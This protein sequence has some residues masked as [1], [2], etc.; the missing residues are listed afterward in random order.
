[1]KKHL[2]SLTVFIASLSSLSAKIIETQ[3]F[4]EIKNHITKNTLILLDIDDTL[5][6]PTQMLG[7]DLWFIDRLNQHIKAGLTKAEALERSLAEWEAIRHLTKM[8][9]VEEGTEGI[10][11][12]MQEEEYTI[13]GLTTQGLALAT[14][15]SLQ[16]KEKG[17]DLSKTA[18]SKKD[19]CLS[20]GEHGVLYRS[21]ILFTSG[22]NKG[23]SLFKLLDALQLDP[24]KIVFINDKETHLKE[25]ERVAEALGVEFIGLRYAYSDA[26]KAAYDSKLAEVQFANSTLKHLL[27]DKEAQELMQSEDKN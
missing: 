24:P 22:T 27:S 4:K 18:P 12:A 8:D 5:L 7:C 9:I 26:K 16:L 14:R 15:T 1:M 17:I 25:I 20:V 2:I 21:G 11:Q 13:M 10:V 3:N 23:R 6:I 19:V